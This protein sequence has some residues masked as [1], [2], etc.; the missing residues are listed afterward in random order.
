MLKG[1]REKERANKKSKRPSNDE[2]KKNMDGFVEQIKFL[3]CIFSG[4]LLIFFI[5]GL[6]LLNKVSKKQKKSVKF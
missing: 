5:L 6:I 1:Q 3:G 4:V 2:T